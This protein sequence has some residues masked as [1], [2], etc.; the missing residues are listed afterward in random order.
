MV[1]K[2]YHIV[3]TKSLRP[4]ERRASG[5]AAVSTLTTAFTDDAKKRQ[6]IEIQL[7]LLSE[8]TILAFLGRI[9]GRNVAWL[10]E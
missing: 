8:S 10:R 4:C 6:N 5:A 3:F 9:Y 1:N 2:D 7:M